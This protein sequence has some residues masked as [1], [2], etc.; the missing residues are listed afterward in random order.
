[1]KPLKVILLAKNAPE[2]VNV[3]INFFKSVGVCAVKLDDGSYNIAGR[4]VTFYRHGVISAMH[5]DEIQVTNLPEQ[6]PLGPLHDAH[7]VYILGRRLAAMLTWNTVYADDHNGYVSRMRMYTLHVIMPYMT[8]IKNKTKEYKYKLITHFNNRVY[9]HSDKTISIKRNTVQGVDFNKLDCSLY[10]ENIKA[11]QMSSLVSVRVIKS[12]ARQD[13]L[14]V[15]KLAVGADIAVEIIK[16]DT[17]NQA[18]VDY[19][20]KFKF[21][22]E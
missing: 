9:I 15:L 6:S 3:I 20:I 4:S 1:M 19:D 12:I 5:T 10:F 7:M 18:I 13:H 14:V 22:F 2:P 21:G 16:I 11:E 8:E 17:M